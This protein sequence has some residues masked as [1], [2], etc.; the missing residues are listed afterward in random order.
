MLTFLRRFQPFYPRRYASASLVFLFLIGIGLPFGL[1]TVAQANQSSPP[2]LIAQAAGGDEAEGADNSEAGAGVKAAVAALETDAPVTQAESGG[3]YVLEFNRSPLVGNRLRLEGIYDETRL[4]FTRPRNWQ[5]ESVNLLLHFRHSA[6]LYATRSNLNVLV[7]GTSVGSIPLNLPQGE[8]GDTVFEV[9]VDLLQNY[10]EVVIAALQNNSPTCTQDALD[11]SLWT[12][13]LPDSKLVF[14]F[15][16]QPITL[17]FAQYPY[18]LFDDLSLTPNQ[19]AYLQPDEVD[20]AWLTAAAQMQVS[21][22]RIAEYRPMEAR[23]TETLESDRPNERLIVIGTP[24]AQPLLSELDLPFE[25]EDSQLTSESEPLPTET[26]VLILT[27]SPD[28]DRPVLVATGNSEMAVD[29]AVQFLSQPVDWQIATGHTMLVDE[30]TPVPSP[31]PRDWPRFLPAEDNFDLADLKDFLGQPI[32]DVTVRGSNAPALEFDFRALP[33][34]RFLPG[35]TMTLEYSYGPQVNPLTSLVEVQLDGVGLDGNRLTSIDGAER[36]TMSVVLPEDQITP[37]SKIRVNF[38]L[39]PRERRSCSRVTDA[40]LWGT[41]HAETSFDLNREI[42]VR[43]PDLK[44]LQAGYPFAAPQDLSDTAVVMPDQPVD[45]DIELLLEFAERLGRLS[46][47]DTIDLQVFRVG[48]LPEETRD[49]HNLVG[50]GAQERFPLPEIF[51]DSGFKLK[52]AFSRQWRQSSIQTLPDHEGLVKQVLSPWNEE[53]V[54][55]A[56]SGQTEIGLRQVQQLLAQDVLFFQ[57]RG[58][59]VLVKADGKAPISDDPNDYSLE[60]LTQAPVQ[61]EII[62]KSAPSRLRHLFRTNWLI[63]GAGML[64]ATLLL[65]GILQLY[66]KRY[67]TVGD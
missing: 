33:E 67:R 5:V 30:V 19:I 38:Q 16:P 36:Q 59:T 12:E 2:A 57:L 63:L 35:N 46:K 26:G 47:A 66:I 43:I 48:Q 55:M 58:D 8:I 3:E 53:R 41:I 44:L 62:E 25:L 51:E 6:A 18:P 20:E 13:I 14:D 50:I 15:Q 39:D 17:N 28:G 7:N 1:A 9:P 21:L 52:E 31:S 34:D 40:Q 37:Q 22:G 49:A 23:V 27:T 54:L 42:G 60:F 56:L 61:A 64:A 32:G 29:K 45:T 65:Y 11:P 10:N 4:R 24:K